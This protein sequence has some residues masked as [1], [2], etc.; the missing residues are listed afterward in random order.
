M[1]FDLATFLVCSPQL[2]NEDSRTFLNGEALFGIS[3]GATTRAFVLIVAHEEF[4]AEILVHALLKSHLH[5]FVC[6]GD[7]E[8]NG[9]EVL[10]GAA[11]LLA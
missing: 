7:L 4:S 2:N 3:M 8:R 10:K 9:G 5:L 1:S 11:C 6:L